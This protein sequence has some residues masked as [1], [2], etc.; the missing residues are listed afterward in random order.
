MTACDTPLLDL[1]TNMTEAS[2]EACELDPETLILARIA[3]LVAAD[4]P[5]I[6]Y[7]M[8][9]GNARDFD[10]DPERIRGILVAIAPVV[11]TARVTS[12]IANIA[13]AYEIELEVDATF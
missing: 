10:V 1:L 11:G 12:A 3:A 13:K 4:A 7:Y 8:N 6:S 2:F 9:L 5:P